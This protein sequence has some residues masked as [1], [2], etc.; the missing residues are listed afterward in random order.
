MKQ[1][2]NGKSHPLYMTAVLA[3]RRESCRQPWAGSEDLT[4][5]RMYRFCRR[6]HTFKLAI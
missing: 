3:P 1:A 5:E 6:G 4:D 2:Y